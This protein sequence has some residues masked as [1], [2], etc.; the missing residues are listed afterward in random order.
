M[1]KYNGQKFFAIDGDITTVYDIYGNKTEK[2]NF[3]MTR[4]YSAYLKEKSEYEAKMEVIK[5]REKLEHEFKTYGEVD[6]V[7]YQRLLRLVA[8]RG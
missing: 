5:L 2:Q 7:D 3:H 8:E 1:E 6:E 4:K